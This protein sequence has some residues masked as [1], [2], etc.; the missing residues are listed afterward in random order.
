MNSAEQ[1]DFIDQQE[2]RISTMMGDRPV[3]L[4]GD[5]LRV[6]KSFVDRYAARNAAPGELGAESIGVIYG[7]ARPYVPLIARSFAARKVP[8][9]IGIYLPVIESAY[10]NCF[11]N[12]IGAK[13]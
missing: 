8:A 10:R 4:N 6:I 12:S 13:G 5:A 1:L 9:I 2:Q 7:R 11:E 3:K